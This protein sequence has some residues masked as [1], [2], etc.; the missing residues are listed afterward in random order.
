MKKTA[1]S[2]TRSFEEG[3]S[4]TVVNI[5]WKNVEFTSGIPS[6]KRF[7]GF[8]E[9]DQIITADITVNATWLPEAKKG[10]YKYSV[11]DLIEISNDIADKS[12][13][14]VVW[15]EFYSYAINGFY[16]DPNTGK[17]TGED[18]CVPMGSNKNAYNHWAM[19]K[20]GKLYDEEGFLDTDNDT[21]QCRIVGLRQFINGDMG[22]TGLVFMTTHSLN[23]DN[24]VYNSINATYG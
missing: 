3:S 17:F 22:V 8:D 12:Q 6:G 14:S 18:N 1:S 9:T 20:N 2:F 23:T 24:T 16:R 10:L 21:V 5:E 19:D 11:N 13:L 15:D 4:L 7:G